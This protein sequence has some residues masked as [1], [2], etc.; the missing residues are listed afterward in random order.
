MTNIDAADLAD[1][2]LL[3]QLAAAATTVTLADGEKK[4]QDLKFAA[5]R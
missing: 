2:T 4:T 1:A 5:S 3:K